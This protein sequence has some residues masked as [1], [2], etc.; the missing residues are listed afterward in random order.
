MDLV[1][2]HRRAMAE[3]DRRVQQLT[4]DRWHVD[5]PCEEWDA[6]TLVN[7]LVVEQL[8]VPHL[9]SGATLEQVGDRFDGDQLGDDPVGA[10]TRAAGPAREAVGTAGALDR[11]VHTSMGELPASEYVTQLTMDLAIHAWDLA[12]ALEIDDTLDAELVGELHRVWA[13]R[14]DELSGSGLFAPAI[15]VGADADPQTRLLA[16][17]GRDARRG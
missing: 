5:T 9:L 3:F 11:T 17:L 10:W 14:A 8:W 2:Q 13:P 15:E 12:R 6:R 16:E 7:H 1:E 4:E